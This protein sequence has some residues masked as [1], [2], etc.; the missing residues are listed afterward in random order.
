LLSNMGLGML[1]RRRTAA[2]CPPTN[3][4]NKFVN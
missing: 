2:P 4:G 3:D 1:T